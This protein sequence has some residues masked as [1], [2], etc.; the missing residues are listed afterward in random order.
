[1]SN[2]FSLKQDRFLLILLLA[3][4]GLVVSAVVLFFVRSGEQEYGPTDT[5]EGVVRNYILA[6]QKGDY[7]TAYS[8]LALDADLPSLEQFENGLLAQR[9]T[10]DSLSVRLGTAV[11]AGQTAMVRLIVLHTS[12]GPFQDTWQ[13]ETSVT[14]RLDAAGD[15]KITAAP[16]PFW[17]PGL[18]KGITPSQ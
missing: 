2:R 8:L 6:L 3:L 7:P 12:G 9:Q 11:Q 1:M 13:D 14:L 18:D 17:A 16:W 10:F 5:P 4:G 15:W